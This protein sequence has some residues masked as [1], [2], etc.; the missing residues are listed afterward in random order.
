VDTCTYY[1]STG[2]CL[3]HPNTLPMSLRTARSEEEYF[4]A[5]QGGKLKH[6]YDEPTLVD[7]K[8][9]RII[10]NNFPY[11]AAYSTSHMLVP[12]RI[13]GTYD[14]LNWRERREMRKIIDTY[15][16]DNYHQVVENMT[17]KRSVLALYHIHL[18]RFVDSRE[19]F[20]L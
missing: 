20:Q 14:R 11:D 6:L 1:D 13:L 7:F 16:Q 3:G 17:S 10:A 2:R 8:H 9:W 4:R 15:C 18:L 12:R 5:K 19:E